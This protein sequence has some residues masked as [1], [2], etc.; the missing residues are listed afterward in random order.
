[1]NLNRTLYLYRTLNLKR[2]LLLSFFL[3]S[4]LCQW[5]WAE[6]LSAA[7]TVVFKGMCDASGAVPLNAKQF[8][9]ADDED[10]LLRIYDADT[11]GAPIG[12]VELSPHQLGLGAQAK[13]KQGHP[14]PLELDL[15]AA[16]RLGDTSFWL[17]SH[18][19][20][21]KG[22]HKLERYQFIALT[23]QGQ[24]WRP[25]GKPYGGL[26]ASLAAA[27][28]YG[29]FNLAEAALGGAKD[30]EGLNIEGMTARP[31]GALYIGFRNPVPQG[32]AL[33]ASL[34]NPQSVIAGAQP[35]WLAPIQL[36]LNG[37]GIRGLSAWRGDYWIIAGTAGI[38]HNS[39]LYRWAGGAA[40]PSAMALG[41]PADFNPEGFFTP[42]ERGEFM[43]L[44][45]DGSRL[46]DGVE[47][48]KLKDPAQKTFRGL[49]LRPGT[50]A[51]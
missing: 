30:I 42:E 36:D 32:R 2:T 23:G 22:K 49:W 1:M 33:I 34:A 11:G 37:L 6:P 8:M 13:S 12:Q 20:N 9:V 25:L 15:E 38:G 39:R 45:D 24:S 46:K 4:G 5:A 40:A 26:L 16:T 29:P 17:T 47:C 21:A 14:R 3:S 50:A 27:P 28:H 31:D 44:S 41:L 19:R 18:A 43:L 10:N 48:K 35:L 51:P 7:Q